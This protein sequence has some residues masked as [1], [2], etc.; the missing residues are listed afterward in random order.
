MSTEEVKTKVNDGENDVHF[1]RYKGLMYNDGI[2]TQTKD[3]NGWVNYGF[4]L[5]IKNNNTVT[6]SMKALKPRI[7]DQI[8][9]VGLCIGSVG[10]LNTHGHYYPGGYM[11]GLM[12]HCNGHIYCNA[13]DI[14]Y[15]GRYA[16]GQ[17]VTTKIINNKTIE[18]YIKHNKVKTINKIDIKSIDDNEVLYPGISMLSLIM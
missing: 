4:N 14:G 8:L 3:Y 1:Y 12:W 17:T 13:A 15:I 9:C 6:L 5:E 11:D 2:L 18:F 7:N 16:I 10:V